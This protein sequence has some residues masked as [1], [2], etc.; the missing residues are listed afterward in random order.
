M[1]D[2]FKV[3]QG[4][5]AADVANAGTFTVGYPSGTDA[6]TFKNGFAHELVIGQNNVLRAPDEFTVSFGASNITITNG[7]GSTWLS[8]SKFYFQADILGESFGEE[9]EA[10]IDAVGVSEATLVTINLGA[11]DTA[12]ADGVCASQSGTA[13]TAMTIAGALA[14]GGVATFDVPR[15]VVGAWTNN[16]KLLITGTDVY[17]N[18]MVEETAT[19]TTSHTGKKAFKTVTSVVPSA[20]ITSATVGTGDV[21]GLPVYL[22]ETGQV[23][24]ELEDGATATAG[25]LVAGANVNP[26]ATTG[27]VR[28]TYDPNSAAD[29]SKAFKLVV[30]LTDPRYKG[31]PQYAG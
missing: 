9:G 16:A 20:N 30:A 10:A 7:S 29:G 24:K 26:T 12:D 17:G 23:L 11:P 22:P 5:L 4:V 3:V 21:L 13:S 14:S 28:G 2:K 19:A 6:S 25:T 1:S 27:D 8:G 18:V 31:A 15:N